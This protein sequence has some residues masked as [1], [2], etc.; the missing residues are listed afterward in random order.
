MGNP[1]MRETPAPRLPSSEPS[2]LLR[3]LFAEENPVNQRVTVALLRQMGHSTA[4]AA[5]WQASLGTEDVQMPEMDGFAAT[6]AIR[7]QER[8]TETAIRLWP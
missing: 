7:A 3:I 4:V 8:S 1:A 5:R 6:R 2:S